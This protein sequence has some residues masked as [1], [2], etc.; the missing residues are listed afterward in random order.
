MTLIAAEGIRIRLDVEPANTMIYAD[1]MLVGQV[2]VN[3]L[4]NAREAVG[5]RRDAC[6]EITSRIDPQENVVIEISNN[7]GAIPARSNRKYLHAFL[8]DQA[9]RIRHRLS[10][11]RRIMQLHKGSLRLTANT[12]NR[13]TFTL[14]FG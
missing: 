5:T 7:G 3:L 9:R 4:K 2:V 1:Q 6:I 8:H 13:V 10:V 12:D 11:S 14:L